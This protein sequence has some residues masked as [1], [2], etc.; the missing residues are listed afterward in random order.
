MLDAYDSMAG[1][2]DVVD[3]DRV[4]VMMFVAGERGREGQVQEQVGNHTS[5]IT[6]HTSHI[7]HHTS[8]ITHH[9]SEITRVR[10]LFSKNVL[11]F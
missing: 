1:S 4:A 2:D 11:S 8:H 6:H 3:D 5:H 9:T 7:A 10:F